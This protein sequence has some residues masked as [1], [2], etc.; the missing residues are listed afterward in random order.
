M[1]GPLTALPM[2]ARL[3]GVLLPLGALLLTPW[4]GAA[5]EF[6]IT[7]FAGGFNVEGVPANQV[8]LNQPSGVAVDRWGNIYIADTRRRLIRKVDSTGTIT[9]IAGPRDVLFGG[10]GGPANQAWLR[11]GSGADSPRELAIMGYGASQNET[12]SSIC[13][14][15]VRR[16]HHSPLPS[17]VFSL[18][19]QLPGFGRDSW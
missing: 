5:Q 12:E 19:T 1:R 9:T 10:D 14:T 11:G 13:R 4:P 15:L 3:L 2:F 18:Q 7:T 16:R 8:P 6:T 17:L